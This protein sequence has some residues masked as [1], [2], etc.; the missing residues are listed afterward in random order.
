MADTTELRV[1]LPREEVSVLDGY[2]QGTG[3]DRTKVLRRI[4]REW[5]DAK[6]HEATLVLRVAG[7][8]PHAPEGGRQ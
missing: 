7:R 2:C 4:L 6:L 8:N 3:Q 5:S 1:E